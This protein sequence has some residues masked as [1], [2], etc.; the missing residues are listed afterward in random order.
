[1]IITFNVETL[2]PDTN[3]PLKTSFITFEVT[4][5]TFK[6]QLKMVVSKERL[7][8]TD[9]EKVGWMFETRYIILARYIGHSE[10]K[11]CFIGKRFCISVLQIF[12][13]TLLFISWFHGFVYSLK[14]HGYGY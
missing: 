8:K 5:A 4:I 11:K 10:E 1:M 12:S 13:S 3:P 9:V 7:G 14:V 6:N 2:N